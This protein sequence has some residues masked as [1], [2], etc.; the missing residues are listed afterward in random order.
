MKPIIKY[1]GGKSKEIPQFINYIPQFEGR[2]IEPFFGGGALY[3]HLE[4]ARAIIN[5]INTR[6]IDFYRGI[7]LHFPEVKVQLSEI[8][9]IYTENRATFDQLK[10]LNPDSRVED[11]NESLYYSIRDMYNGLVDSRYLFATLYY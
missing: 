6:L 9:K 2:Y 4:P 11:N 7:Q 10:K 3:F 8:E 1:R 5:D